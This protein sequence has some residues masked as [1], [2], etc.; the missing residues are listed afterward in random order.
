M[1]VFIKRHPAFAGK[2]IYE[3]YF[4]AWQNQG[5]E[6]V[7][8]DNLASIPDGTYD[9]MA[10]DADVRTPEDL[11][12]LQNARR[13]YLFVQPTHYPMPWGRHPNFVS[14]MPIEMREPVK[15]LSNAY[16]WSFAE[17]SET[18]FYSDWGNVTTVH[19]A[20]DSLSYH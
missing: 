20:F 19:L 3:G 8:Y 15:E 7:Y 17:A 18:D 9:L 4:A 2:W 11:K 6:P 1:K 12:A 13:V 5:F 10:L 14:Q 16:L